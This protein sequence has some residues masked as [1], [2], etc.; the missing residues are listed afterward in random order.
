MEGKF[1]QAKPRFSLNRVTAKLSNTSETAIAITFLVMN[2]ERLLWALFFVLLSW[3]VGFTRCFW[4]AKVSDYQ[5]N[6]LQHTPIA[7]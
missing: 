3:A 5:P 4:L 6:N 2:V 7:A 1:G